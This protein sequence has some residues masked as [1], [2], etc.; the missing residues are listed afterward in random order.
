MAKYL[1]VLLALGLTLGACKGKKEEPKMD[2]EV[3]EALKEQEAQLTP[4]PEL[5]E[6]HEEKEKTE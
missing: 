5:E 4:I 6:T 3:A 2:E 1:V